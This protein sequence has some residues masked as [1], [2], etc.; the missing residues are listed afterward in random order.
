M[1]EC[2]LQFICLIKN[3]LRQ[4]N[5]DCEKCKNYEWKNIFELSQ[6]HSVSGI[7]ASQILNFSDK[8]FL[9]EEIISYSKQVLC[10]TVQEYEIKKEMVNDISEIL[11]KSEIRH[12]FIKGT[13]IKELYPQSELRTSGDID[14]YVKADDFETAEKV[15]ENNN[16][17]KVLK[18]SDVSVFVKNSQEIELHSK[19]KSK[20]PDDKSIFEYCETANGFSYFPLKYFHFAYVVSHLAK[21][22]AQ[23]GAGVRMFMDIDVLYGC[24]NAKE[25]KKAFEIL[26]K[27]NL[28][29]T[30]TALLNMCRVWF[31]TPIEDDLK[32]DDEKLFEKMSRIVL[33][34]GTFG[35]ESGKAGKV[36]LQN[37]IGKSD[38]VSVF[39]RLKALQKLFFPSVSYLKSIY[40]FCEK[41]PILV[42]AAWFYRLFCAVFKRGNH[43]KNTIKEILSQNS[44]PEIYNDVLCELGLLKD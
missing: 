6:K 37:S 29:K 34:G 23:G 25:K 17:K 20:I 8:S 12:I 10:K 36:Y 13:A 1:T 42:P 31:D 30:A 41:N 21:H 18:R 22:L 28:Y 4:L 14:V 15:F 26:K 3:F 44:V 7:I 24:L 27:L 5:T 38:R 40:G 32:N 35:F 11:S 16:F 33:E 2:E 19:I 43:S 9:S 39:T